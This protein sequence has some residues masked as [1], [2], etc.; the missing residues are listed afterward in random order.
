[1]AYSPTFKSV[2]SLVPQPLRVCQQL[3]GVQNVNQ[4]RD[5][6]VNCYR[7]FLGYSNEWQNPAIYWALQTTLIQLLT[8]AGRNPKAVRLAI[9]PDRFPANP[10]PTFYIQTGG[11]KNKA[12][13]LAT[14]QVLTEYPPQQVKEALTDI[15]I[16]FHS[17]P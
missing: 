10:F 4:V 12:Y 17:V 11:D 7:R 13:E 8:D 5:A 16:D 14:A 1:M 9:S 6:V 3:Y 15:Y 2:M